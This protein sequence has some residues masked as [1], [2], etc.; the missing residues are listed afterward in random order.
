MEYLLIGAIVFTAAII[1][2]QAASIW[3][4]TDYIAILAKKLF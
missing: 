4:E 3:D 1:I 2:I